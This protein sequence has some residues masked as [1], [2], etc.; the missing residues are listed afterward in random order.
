MFLFLFFSLTACKASSDN[1][2]IVVFIKNDFKNY[3]TDNRKLVIEANKDIKKEPAIKEIIFNNTFIKLRTAE[4]LLND[5]YNSW[6]VGLDKNDFDYSDLNDIC[7][8]VVYMEN[9]V[10]NMDS[11]YEKNMTKDTQTSV[12]NFY[13]M[14]P[15]I[16]E[17]RDS[18]DQA[19]KPLVEV[20]K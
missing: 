14:K 20:C 3:I 6:L 5:E 7:W 11:S 12:K 13:E 1:E 17:L 19:A 10:K 15:K 4:N 9:Y 18:K 2:D 16:I 8:M